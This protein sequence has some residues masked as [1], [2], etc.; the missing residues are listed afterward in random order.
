[1]RKL[2]GVASLASFRRRVSMSVASRAAIRAAAIHRS[3]LHG[4]YP[5]L[6]DLTGER[7]AA[8]FA[9]GRGR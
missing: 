1:M 7:G 9:F 8:A 2:I 6:T 4:D 5:L 3:L